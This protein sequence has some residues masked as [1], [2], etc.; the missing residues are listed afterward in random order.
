[1]SADLEKT[2]MEKARKWLEGNY[3]EKTKERVKYL[4]DND[5]KELVESF[6]QD[7]E[8]GTG[9]L[10]GIMGV[11]TN[12]MNIYTVGMATQGLANYLKKEFPGQRI[13]VA[14]GHDSRNNS[15]LF[16]E[17]V[18]AIF[19]ANGF[20]VYLFDSLRPTP[21]LSFAIRQLGCKSG[22]VITAS[23]NPKEYNGYKAYWTDGAQVTAPHDRNIIDEVKKIASVDEVLTQ[24]NG[25]NITILDENFD[26][27]YLDRVHGLS[28]SPD[29]VAAHADMK[30]VYTPLHGSGVVLVPASLRRFGFRNVVTVREQ[31][32]T[33]GNFPTV[34]SP[35]PEERS[36]RKMAIDLG[37]KEKADLV[38]ATDPDADRIGVALP[39]DTGEFVLLNG[40][41]TC[42]L[43]TYYLLRRWS[44]LDKIHGREYIVKT[45]VTT[46]LMNRIADSFK[47]KCFDCL[48]GFKYIATI[49][50]E[51]EGVMQYIGGGEESFGYLAGD[52]VRD[53]DAVSA[54]SLFAEATAWAKTQGMTLYGLLKDIYLRYGFFKE[55]MVPLVRKGKEGQ[56]E[57]RQMM[58][59]FRANPPKS[60][61]GSPV[62]TIRDYQTGESLDVQGG[63]KTPIEMERSNVLQFLTADS[64]IVSVRPSGT[65]PKIKFYFGVR[66]E[67]PAVTLFDEVQE[68]LDAKIE[69]M[70]K[71]LNLV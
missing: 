59:D 53:K 69:R 56:E 60:I 67:L 34:A 8:F 7:L 45:I 33:D 12:R 9:G 23:H 20:R 2:V 46:E 71:E 64:T 44:E 28:L 14:V 42:V 61:C 1:M 55:G 22:V 51:H 65:E 16:S 40:N 29:A 30:I 17:H 4:I 24:G 25:D 3:D 6:Y 57:I 47:V 11:G 50:R 36:T 41:Q 58:S 26:Q 15:R 18:A 48:T 62:V 37:R 68:K 54:C 21:E 70:K 31:N 63:E 52:F 38:L 19:A 49:I 10:R 27:I 35:T 43:L 5:K 66:E 13:K 39:D 32:I